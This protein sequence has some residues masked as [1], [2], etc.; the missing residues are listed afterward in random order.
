M[1]CLSFVMPPVVEMLPQVSVAKPARSPAAS[2]ALGRSHDISP[3][4]H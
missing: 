3:D 2:G 4:G 1:L